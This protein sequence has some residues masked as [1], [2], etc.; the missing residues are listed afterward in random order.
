M[1]LSIII[2]V[3][4]VEA[5]VGRTLESVFDTTA[6]VVEFE[7]VVVND[8][9]EDRSMAVV[10]R[11]SDRSNLTIL[12]QENQG[13]SAARM[14]GLAQAKGEYVWFVDSDDYLVEDAVRKVLE[15][16][17]ESPGADVLLF[18]RFHVREEGE[19]GRLDFDVLRD[20]VVEGK[21]VIRDSGIPVYPSQ[22][23]ILKRSLFDAP[24][25]FFPP[26]L[27]HEDEYFGP[28]LMCLAKRVRILKD[29]VYY[30]RHRTG[31]L[32]SDMTVRT[33]YDMVSV[34][35][36]LMRFME[37]ALGLEDQGWFRSYCCH[38]LMAGYGRNPQL[39]GTPSFHRFVRK[40]GRYVWKQW[41]KA[42]PKASLKKEAG[43]FLYC[44]M[45]AL[46]MRWRRR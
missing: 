16:L 24:W 20:E 43:K 41:K 10:R 12:E 22:R 4:N 34:H 1:K 32:T 2:P 28:V 14:R 11:F 38:R 5:Y 17:Q 25:L 9:T 21:S 15:R 29:P 23:F 37:N 19:K 31:S 39:F 7:V 36:L 18:P 33:C 8:G 6:P 44:T 3:Y 40:E 46:Y 42:N 13:L 45:P 27:L 26:G 35:R 30:Q